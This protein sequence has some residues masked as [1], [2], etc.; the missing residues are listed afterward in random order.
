GHYR[1]PQRLS[2]SRHP[3]PDASSILVSL[4]V[5]KFFVI[6]PMMARWENDAR[7]P[8]PNRSFAAWKNPVAKQSPP[9]C[10]KNPTLVT[11]ER[12]R[13]RHKAAA[14]GGR[15]RLTRCR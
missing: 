12:V 5:P 7:A 3:A 15:P 13:Q 9:L 14:T 4:E 10:A 2:V 11:L 1:F 6:N 8:T